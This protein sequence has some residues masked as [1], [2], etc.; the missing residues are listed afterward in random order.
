MINALRSASTGMEAQQMRINGI[1]HDLANVNTPGYKKTRSTF[2]DLYYDQV[3]V[4]GTLN[5]QQTPSPNGIQVGHGTRLTSISKIFTQ[6][7]STQT[8]NSLDVSIEGQ[9]FFQVTDANGDTY[10]TRTGSFQTN[11]EREIVTTEG[12]K[13]EPNLSLPDNI[14]SLTIAQDGTV[15][16]IVADADEAQDLGQIELVM[17]PNPAGLQYMGRNIYRLTSASGDPVTVTPGQDGSGLLA[18]GSLENSNVDISESLIT[19][20]VAQ[21]S[22]EANSKVIEAADRMMQQANN[23]I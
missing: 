19:M 3:K 2:E 12:M 8:G 1:A 9:G 23:M 5:N 20:I 7:T 15:S 10:Y 6:G 21:R 17:F 11:A 16:A 4:P 18:Q 13:I 22:Y 14:Q